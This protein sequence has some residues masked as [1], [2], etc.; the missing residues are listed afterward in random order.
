M[1]LITVDRVA[2]QFRVLKRADGVKAVLRALIRPEYETVQAVREM[3]FSLEKG[4]LVGYIGPNG[5]GKSTT[6]KMLSGILVPDAGH[7]EVGGVVPY[8]DRQVNARQIGVVFGQRSSLEWDLPM[9]DTMLLYKRMYKI[10]QKAFDENV[11]FFTEMLD[12]SDFMDRPV[13][14]MSLGQKIRANI[15]VSLLHNPP[16]LY[17]DEPTI[18]LDVVAKAQIRKFIRELNRNRQIT[19]ILTTHD[20]ADIEA[21]CDRIILIDKG[22]KMF[23]GSMDSFKAQHGDEYV[24][25]ITAEDGTTPWEVSGL[26][27]DAQEGTVFTYRGYRHDQTAPQALAL[28]IN[29][30][31]ASQIRDIQVSEPAID[32]IVR[33]LY[34]K[35]G[36]QPAS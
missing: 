9:R 29:G 17:L 24:I 25:R 22:E 6:I 31:M 2:K 35:G 10:D 7:I 5:A 26:K 30:E 19:L 12:M 13:R 8:E 34:Q 21:M 14:N 33:K 28:F 36:K 15:A 4:E 23:D 11:A 20:M 16:I 32:D 1:P 18:G 27:L 3:S